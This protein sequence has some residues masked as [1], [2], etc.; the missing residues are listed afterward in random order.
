MKAQKGHSRFETMDISKLKPYGPWCLI[1]V[2]P[3]KKQSEAGLYLPEGNQLERMG[4]ASGVVLSRGPG[5]FMTKKKRGLLK[6]TPI[7]VEVGEKIVFRGHLQ[8]LNRPG[9]YLDREH[10]LIHGQ[11]IIGVLDKGV[12]LGLALPYDN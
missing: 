3:P 2:D 8:E 10:C 7:G 12:E 9:G 11:D 1:K 6:Y 5:F 4:Y